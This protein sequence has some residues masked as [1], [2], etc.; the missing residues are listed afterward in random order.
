MIMKMRFK[1]ILFFSLFTLSFSILGQ[2]VDIGLTG[3]LS[4]YIGDINPSIQIMNRPKPT[5]GLFYRKNLNKRYALRY[6]VNYAKL[7]ATD[8]VRSTDLSQYRHL[9]F[10]S[11][12]WEAYGVIEFNFIPYQINNRATSR[13]SPFVFIGLAAFKVS[14]EVRGRDLDVL[15]SDLISVSIPF[16]LGVKFNFSGNWGLGIEWGMRKTF[17]D[18][19]DGLPEKYADGYQLSNSQNNDWYSIVGLTLNYKI[20]THK[21][22]CNMPGF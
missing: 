4:Y 8:K 9:S 16:G 10:S 20:L 1:Y 3:G 18:Q 7:T 19:V 6:G 12:L 11:D 2:N 15:G 14:P 13:F 5:I 17:T 22:R 21:D